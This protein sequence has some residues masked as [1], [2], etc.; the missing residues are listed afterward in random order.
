MTVVLKQ[1][2]VIVPEMAKK[3]LRGTRFEDIDFSYRY[4]HENPFP[5][6]TNPGLRKQI[7]S[8]FDR[9]MGMAVPFFV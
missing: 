8:A 6:T 2:K 9:F 3:V 4:V 1:D 5:V 7:N